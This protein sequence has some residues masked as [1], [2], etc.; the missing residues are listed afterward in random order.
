M[1]IAVHSN[2]ICSIIS[3]KKIRLLG[4]FKLISYENFNEL[5][6]EENR[7]GLDYLVVKITIVVGLRQ[8]SY[9]RELGSVEYS[10]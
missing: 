1:R 3:G 7:C 2:G 4:I 6:G 10:W 9:L 8:V 5:W